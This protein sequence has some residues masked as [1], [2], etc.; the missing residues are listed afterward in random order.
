[1][2]QVTMLC[3]RSNCRVIL[4]LRHDLLSDNLRAVGCHPIRSQASRKKT[5]RQPTIWQVLE[6]ED[7]LY[8]D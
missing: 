5:E 6:D 7:I 4:M 2:N 3:A 8:K 1:M